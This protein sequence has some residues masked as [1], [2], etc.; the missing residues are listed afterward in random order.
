MNSLS[1]MIYYINVIANIGAAALA[2]TIVGYVLVVVVVMLYAFFISEEGR[3][4]DTDKKIDTLKKD[5]NK[6]IKRIFITATVAGLVSI[7]AP[8]YKTMMLMAASQ[9]GEQIVNNPK[10]RD[11]VDPSL[12]YLRLWLKHEVKELKEKE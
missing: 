9:V 11:I 7:L 5:R 6:W 4:C 8:D 1:W 12:D 3:G 10:T 2:V